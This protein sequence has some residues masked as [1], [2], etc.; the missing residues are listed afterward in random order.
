MKN[1]PHNFISPF[2][3]KNTRLDEQFSQVRSE[4]VDAFDIYGKFQL[5]SS[6]L[7]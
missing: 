7:D 5:F 6:S 1:H 2:Y 3:M 4:P